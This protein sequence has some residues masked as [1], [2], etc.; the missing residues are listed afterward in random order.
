MDCRP[1]RSWTRLSWGQVRWVRVLTGA[2]Y[3]SPEQ[4]IDRQPEFTSPPARRKLVEIKFHHN[5][6][7]E[8]IRK[9][10]P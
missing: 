10:G 2:M 5:P 4:Q 8:K 7:V 6:E 3:V 9:S 1:T